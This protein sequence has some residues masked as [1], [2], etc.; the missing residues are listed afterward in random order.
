ML[1]T[2]D[3]D[4]KTLL[5]ANPGMFTASRAKEVMVEIR[6]F[7]TAGVESFARGCPFYEQKPGRMDIMGK[8]V[9]VKGEYLENCIQSMQLLVD[10]L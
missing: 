2:I 3:A 9:G 6:D 10:E 7:Q 1:K 4:V 5:A 8:R